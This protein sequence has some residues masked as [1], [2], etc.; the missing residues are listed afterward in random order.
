MERRWHL[1]RGAHTDTEAEGL[2]REEIFR[3]GNLDDA[4]KGTKD[5]GPGLLLRLWDHPAGME[6]VGSFV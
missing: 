3:L 4:D 6:L 2:R 1:A 5:A